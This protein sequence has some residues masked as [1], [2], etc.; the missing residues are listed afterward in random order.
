MNRLWTILSLMIIVLSAGAI[1]IPQIVPPC[2]TMLETVSGTM[3]PMRCH[4]A[5]RAATVIAAMMVLTGVA[6]LFARSTGVRRVLACCVVLDAA[7]VFA[8]LQPQVIGVCANAAMECHR[9]ANLTYG[10][11]VLIVIVA[12]VQILKARGGEKR[13][14]RTY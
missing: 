1:L 7:A 8:V 9:T 6:Q 12:L 14:K 3:T 2:E 5:F 4:W 10:V 13:P 11:L